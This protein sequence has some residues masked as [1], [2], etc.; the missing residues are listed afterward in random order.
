[1]RLAVD[2]SALG[3]GR[4]GDETYMRAILRGLA[5][6]AAEDPTRRVSVY[7]RPGADMRGSFPDFDWHDLRVSGSGRLAGP[8]SWQWRRSNHDVHLAYTHAALGSPARTAL[9]VTDLSFRHVPDMYPRAARLRLNSLV[10][11]QARRAPAVLTLTDFCRN[12]LIDTIGLDPERV[13][14]VP[15]SIDPAAELDDLRRHE[16]ET[17]LRDRGVTGPFVLYLGNLHPRKNVP[18]LIR[19]FAATTAAKDRD[20]Q[21]VIAGGSWWGGGGEQDALAKCPEGSVVMLGRVS[22]VEREVLLRNASV[23][24]YPSLFE[25][26]GLPPLEAMARGTAV[27]ASDRTS[28][29][30]VVGDAALLIDPTDGAMLTEALDRVLHDTDLR[31]DLEARGRTRCERYSP[32]ATGRAAAAALATV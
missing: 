9:V 26:F 13:H 19:S 2:A 30:E 5:A 4:G 16:A 15:C 18:Q 22:E 27:V 29:P 28:I 14:V 31:N 1:M 8:L 24:A 6:T 21:L 20:A 11:V 25:G 10:P 3:S 12:D 23:L 32:E 17:S 7:T